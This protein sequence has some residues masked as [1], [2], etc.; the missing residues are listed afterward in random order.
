MATCATCNKTILFGGVRDGETRFCSTKCLGLG[1][2]VR[3][4]SQVPTEVVHAA[5]QQIHR[6]PC[7]RC[8]RR[9]GPVELYVSHRVWSA[10][11][12]TNTKST[13]TISCRSCATRRKLADT[14]SSLLLGW[15][16]IPWGLVMTPIQVARNLVG[17]L[18]PEGR[19]KAPSPQ[20]ERAVRLQLAA[21]ARPAP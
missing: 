3:A 12:V 17:L 11:V 18:R 10:L 8:G 16:G 6:G 1:A 9:N 21:G 20:L 7:P 13:P 15:W 19:L 4:A 2:L 5:V 14:F